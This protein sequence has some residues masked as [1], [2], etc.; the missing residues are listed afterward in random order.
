MFG[1]SGRKP[2][3]SDALSPFMNPLHGLISQP[4]F[5]HLQVRSSFALA[6]VRPRTAPPFALRPTPTKPQVGPLPH[7]HPKCSHLPHTLKCISYLHTSNLPISKPTNLPTSN[8]SQ[9]PGALAGVGGLPVTV[10][11]AGGKLQA[12]LR[13]AITM[14]EATPQVWEMREGSQVFGRRLSRLG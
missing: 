4:L 12:F 5:G 8:C 2:E 3:Q 1:G 11:S 10:A 13:Q 6:P 14:T 7:S 9:T